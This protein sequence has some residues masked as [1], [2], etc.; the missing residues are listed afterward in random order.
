MPD[1]HAHSQNEAEQTVHEL[2]TR[3]LIVISHDSAGGDPITGWHLEEAFQAQQTR[4][5]KLVA[6]GLD[7]EQR[8]F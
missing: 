6:D 7:W 4:V 1:P 8:L 5:I 3:Y 2:L